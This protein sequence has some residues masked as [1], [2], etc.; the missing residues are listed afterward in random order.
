MSV[1]LAIR[2]KFLEEIS[3]PSFVVHPTSADMEAREVYWRANACSDYGDYLE[4][5][6]RFSR[7]LESKDEANQQLNQLIQREERE[8]VISGNLFSCYI[9]FFYENFLFLFL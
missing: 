1:P 5:L 3:I 7:G 9:Y 6:V 4:S 2:I 8:R